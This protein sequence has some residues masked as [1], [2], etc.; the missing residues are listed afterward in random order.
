MSDPP[1]EPAPPTLDELQRTLTTALER[2]DLAEAKI[3]HL[4][5]CRQTDHL[6]ADLIRLEHN[7]HMTNFHGCGE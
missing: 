1:A 6:D 3:L 7:H 2:L 5:R 4:D